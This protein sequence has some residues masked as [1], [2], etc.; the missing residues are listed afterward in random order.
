MKS[1]HTAK[2]LTNTQNLRK[3]KAKMIEGIDDPE[4][5]GWGAERAVTRKVVPTVCHHYG[6]GGK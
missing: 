6:W 1:H 5:L 2:T 4:G 3:V